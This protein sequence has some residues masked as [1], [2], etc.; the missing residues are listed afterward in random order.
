MSTHETYED[1][2]HISIEDAI[3]CDICNPR[4]FSGRSYSA[5]L[6]DGAD[7]RD[8]NTSTFVNNTDYPSP[9]VFRSTMQ[10]LEFANNYISAPETWGNRYSQSIEGIE[11]EFD[12]DSGDW[13]ESE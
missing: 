1:A 12:V 9:V 3:D 2:N 13:K 4:D 11:I 7:P 6:D 10:F 8:D 5:I